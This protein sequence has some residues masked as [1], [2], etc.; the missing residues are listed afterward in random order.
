M[1]ILDVILHLIL[2]GLALISVLMLAGYLP[3]EAEDEE[4]L[5]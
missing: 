3:N 1:T 2:A 4:D 5:W